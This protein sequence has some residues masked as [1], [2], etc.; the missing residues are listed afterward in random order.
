MNLIP[1]LALKN[2]SRNRR[3]TALTTISIVAGVGMFI[4]GEAFIEGVEENI[5]RSAEE[6]NV[7]H[8]LARP[9][10]YPTQGMNAPLDRLLDITPAARTLLDTKTVAWTGRVLFGPTAV[11]AAE[12]IRVRA[13]GYE[14][15]R[16]E[17]VFPRTQWKIEGREPAANADEVLISPSVARLLSLKTGE[18]F[19]LQVRTHHGAINALEVTVAGIG[20]TGN[21]GL[22]A[23]GLFAPMALTTKLTGADAP[24]H[25]LVKLGRRSAAAD[26][27]PQL[28]AAMG[29]SAEVATLAEETAEMLSLQQTR[30]KSLNVLVFILLALAG[31]GMANTFLMAAYERTREVGTLRAMGMTEGSVVRLFITE[32]FLVGAIGSLLGAALGGGYAAWM[33]V[34]PWDISKIVTGSG[35]NNLSLSALIYTNLEPG[36]V[37]LGVFLGLSVSLLSSWYPARV[38]SALRPADA[39]RG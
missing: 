39:V 26:F 33:T 34:H 11:H 21:M 27:K 7:A 17:K 24:T 13:I 8:V 10:N 30:R 19:V 22:D 29:P 23:M 15:G 9:E 4:L 5:T 14:P 32:G 28:Q 36:T 31:F 37:A 35:A 18:R 6:G 1:K 16:D 12:S 38:A 25:V 2:L 3:R 20:S